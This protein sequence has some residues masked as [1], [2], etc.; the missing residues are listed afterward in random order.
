[1]RLLN[2]IANAHAKGV[3]SVAACGSIIASGGYDGNLRLWTL[4]KQSLRLLHEVD[5]DVAAD[6]AS[7][8]FSVA[9]EALGDGQ[10]MLAAGSY[11][12]RLRVW[13]CDS[14]SASPQLRWHSAQHTGWV[15]SLAWLL[16]RR[17]RRH[18]ATRPLPHRRGARTHRAGGDAR[19]GA[20]DLSTTLSDCT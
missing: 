14:I 2:S 18:R 4:E 12:R 8:I 5:V 11:C 13:H 3:I 15:R 20:Q 7:P 17:S 19:A 9:L 6:S 1:M 10:L 16:G